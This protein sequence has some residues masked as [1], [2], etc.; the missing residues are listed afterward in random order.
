MPHVQHKETR[1]RDPQMVDPVCVVKSW[2]QRLDR[3]EPGLTRQAGRGAVR[4]KLT[5]L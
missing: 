4:C 1:H 2:R 3:A 5:V